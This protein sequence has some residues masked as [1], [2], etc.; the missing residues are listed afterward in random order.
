M[1]RHLL[2]VLPLVFIAG[3]SSCVYFG[4]NAPPKPP[5]G[6]TVTWPGV[7]FSEVRAYCYDYTAEKPRSFFVGSRM[8]VGVM[9]PRGVRLNAEQIRRLVAAVTMS[10]DKQKRT[11]CYK[12]HH[13]F[14]FYDAKGKAAAV[15][16][17]C[18]GC[19]KFE[20]TPE[21]LPEYVDTPALWN[22]CQEL[23]LPL[24]VGN[25]FYTEACR[26]G[27]AAAGN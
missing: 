14:V 9:D 2:C 13:S 3:L 6:T 19:N 5:P 10:H 12:P 15:F 17:M 11:P 26:Q 22:L 23:G 1:I 25:E 7:P 4:V 8:H 24:G 20:E 18:F 27:R 21:G 16:E